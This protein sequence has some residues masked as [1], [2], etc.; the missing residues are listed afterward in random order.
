MDVVEA[1][2]SRRVIIDF[3][4]T[5]WIRCYGIEFSMDYKLYRSSGC[6]Q[7]V[8]ATKV[9]LSVLIATTFCKT[10]KIN[11]KFEINHICATCCHFFDNKCFCTQYNYRRVQFWS[12]SLSDHHWTHLR[13]IHTHAALRLIARVAALRCAFGCHFPLLLLFL[14]ICIFVSI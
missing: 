4:A 14:E 3:I 6:H 1:A 13:C 12:L 9:L 11:D 10:L 7:I 2:K 8:T 5:V